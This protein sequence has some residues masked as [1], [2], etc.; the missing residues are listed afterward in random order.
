MQAKEEELKEATQRYFANKKLIDAAS[1]EFNIKSYFVIQ[2]VPTYKYNLSNHII[3]Q[4]NPDILDQ[5]VNS[6]LGYKVLEKHYLN[7]NRAE[8]ENIIWLADIQTNKKENL[9]VDSVHYN[10]D[11][12]EEIADEIVNIIKLDLFE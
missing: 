12:S 4:R 9:Y 10:A 6:F 7:L 8:K 2:P 5:E 3:F 11:F 1:K